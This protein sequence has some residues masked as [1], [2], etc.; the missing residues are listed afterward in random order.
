SYLLYTII[1][2][3]VYFRLYRLEVSRASMYNLLWTLAVASGVMTAMETGQTVIAA[4]ITAIS[5][6]IAIRQVI[7]LWKR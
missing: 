6:G 5:I 3:I 2:A 4:I 1:I 7:T